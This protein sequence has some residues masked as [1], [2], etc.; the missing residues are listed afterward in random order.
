M[1]LM[2]RN[3]RAERNHP[4]ILAFDSG[5]LM[6]EPLAGL[7]R[8]DHAVNAGLLL[9][10][11]CLR[12]GDRVGLAGF[13]ARL[14]RFLEPRGGVQAFPRLQ[15]ESAALDYSP[16]ETNFTLGL[17][18]LVKKLRRRSLVVV[19]TDFVDTVTAELMLD[20]LDQLAR[21]H[22]VLFVALRD[23]VLRQ[24][25]RREPRQLVDLNRAVV[26]ADLHRERE[27]VFRRL[28]QSGILLLDVEPSGLSVDLVNRYFDIKRRELV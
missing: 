13:D 28:V 11:F 5:H 18:E 10:Y 16:V 25:E 7:P 21:R 8:L 24:L 2:C 15:N 19:F 1:K 20:G 26:A 22:V 17:L 23:P 14:N 6:G 4:I 9:A 27:L 3:F 12:T